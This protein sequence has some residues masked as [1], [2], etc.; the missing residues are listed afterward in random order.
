[1]KEPNPF[2]RGIPDPSEIVGRVE[3]IQIFDSYLDGTIKNKA[4]R[5]LI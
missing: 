4:N 2:T 3:Q 5:Y 1:M